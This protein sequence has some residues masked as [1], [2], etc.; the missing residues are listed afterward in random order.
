[1]AVVYVPS[2]IMSKSNRESSNKTRGRRRKP[3]KKKKGEI[4]TTESKDDINVNNK[5]DEK[6]RKAFLKRYNTDN[7]NKWCCENCLVWNDCI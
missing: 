7:T 1:M 6:G 3:N 2:P 5:I 4:Q